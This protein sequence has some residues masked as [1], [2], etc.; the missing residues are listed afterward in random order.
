MADAGFKQVQT[1]QKKIDANNAKI[2]SITKKMKELSESGAPRTRIMALLKQRKMLSEQNVA[3]DNQI[4]PLMEMDVNVM[5][6]KT[7]KL[8]RELSN[9]PEA[10]PYFYSR[11]EKDPKYADIAKKRTSMRMRG[12]N[13]GPWT[14][15]LMSQELRSLEIEDDAVDST[16]AAVA[17][18]MGQ[19]KKKSKKPKKSMKR[20]KSRGKTRRNMSRR[21][22]R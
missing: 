6:L 17:K 2:D 3:L 16:L 4:I 10:N 13:P 22:R 14:S 21:R 9:D 18:Q 7:S 20:S 8:Q 12:K 5:G 19:K 1:L 11:K 15:D